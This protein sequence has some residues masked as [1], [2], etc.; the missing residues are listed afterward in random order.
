MV[1]PRAIRILT[2]SSCLPS[3]EI[4]EIEEYEEEVDEEEDEEEETGLVR[5]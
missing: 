5:R 1:A 4:E 3:T 2:R